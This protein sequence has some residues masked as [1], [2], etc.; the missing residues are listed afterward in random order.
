M[1]ERLLLLLLLFL[2]VLPMLTP[3]TAVSKQPV[4]MVKAENA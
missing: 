2:S 4:K 1:P 3:A